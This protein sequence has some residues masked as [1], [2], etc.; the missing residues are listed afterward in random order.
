MANTV[1]ALKK[2]GTSTTTPTSLE[3]GELAINYADGKIFYKNS[4][5]EIVEFAPQSSLG[6]YFGTV[7][8]SGTLIV[9]DTA[10]DYLTLLAGPN[11]TITGDAINDTITISATASGN[12]G[13]ASV[14]VGNNEPTN[15]S[16]GDLWWNTDL[17]RLLVYYTDEDSSQWVD[18]SPTGDI[19]PTGPQGP[20]GPKSV[21]IVYPTASEDVTLF[22]TESQLTI[23]RISSVFIG[24]GGSTVDFTI[25]YDSDRTST[26]TEVIT[27]GITCSSSTTSNNETVFNNATIPANNFIW[28]ETSSITGSVQEFHIT[29]TF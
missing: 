3:F 6:N 10:D 8:A 19:G 1:I 13:G 24:T 11:I 12:G 17:G 21:T 15:N 25:R 4:S 29:L 23:S 14:N 7:N 2:S 18:A 5:S 9:A 22:Y 28:L 27:G 20:S 26:G 16:S